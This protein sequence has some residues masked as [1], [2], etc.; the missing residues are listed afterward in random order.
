MSRRNKTKS[1]RDDSRHCGFPTKSGKPCRAH[2]QMS[3]GGEIIGCHLHDPR[4]L[5]HAQHEATIA[6]A[7]RRDA[8]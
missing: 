7:K 6:Y 5:T 8:A 3:A 4:R 2:A 1:Q